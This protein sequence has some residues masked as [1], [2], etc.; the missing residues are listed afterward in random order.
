MKKKI[1]LGVFV[2]FIGGLIF[3]ITQIMNNPDKYNTKKDIEV[4][5]NTNEYSRISTDELKSKLGEPS[6]IEDWNSETSK[7]TFQMQIYTYKQDEDYYEFISY[8]D[9]VVKV[10]CFG[11][12]KYNKN[13]D[14]IFTMFGIEPGKDAKK[15]VDTG[16]T[17]KFSP[18]SNKVAEFEVFNFNEDERSFDTVYI[19]YNLNYFD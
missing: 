7:G 19:T 6:S 3:G 17:Y 13:K 16:V 11:N 10:H 8:D 15:T 1:A 14:D 2:L 9:I 18:V 4:V 5:F 12:W